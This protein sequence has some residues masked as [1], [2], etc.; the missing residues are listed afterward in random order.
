MLI[1]FPSLNH[2]FVEIGLN[3]HFVEILLTPLRGNTNNEQLRKNTFINYIIIKHNI[4]FKG[5]LVLH[6]YVQFSLFLDS[7]HRFFLVMLVDLLMMVN[8]Q[9]VHD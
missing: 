2:H 9:K 4:T 3:L 1:I 6:L 5:H 7:F 8:Y